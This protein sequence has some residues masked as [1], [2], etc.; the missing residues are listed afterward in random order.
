[1]EIMKRPAPTVGL[2][3]TNCGEENGVHMALKT[4]CSNNAKDTPYA[5]EPGAPLLPRARRAET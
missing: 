5:S 2:H 1:V 3:H 4:Q